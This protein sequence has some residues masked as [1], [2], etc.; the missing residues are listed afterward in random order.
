M[1]CDS[2]K[3]V[4]LIDG[5]GYIFR[6]YYALQHLTTS[7]GFPTNAL[8][9]FTKM[10]LKLLEDACVEKVVVCFDVSK[11]TFRK[12]I[13]PEYKANR[14]ACPEDLVPQLPFFRSICLALGLTIAE[15]DG[16]EADDMI[17]TLTQRLVASGS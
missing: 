5:S 15:K 11:E 1:E 4:Y 2:D 16:Y 10:L 17:G 13:Y 8:Y 14:V 12:Q 7:Y 3:K 9:G 6:A